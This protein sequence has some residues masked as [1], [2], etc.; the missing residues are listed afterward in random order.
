MEDLAKL[1]R[2][3]I[4][5]MPAA[6]RRWVLP[7]PPALGR[8][9]LAAL[10]WSAGPDL[11]SL[12][13]IEP[14]RPLSELSVR[15]WTQQSGI[16]EESITSL[17]FTPDGYV[18]GTSLN[19]LIRFDGKN[20][21]VLFPSRGT[22]CNDDTLA[23][24]TLADNGELWAA[25]SRGCLY[26]I[27]PD[28][29]GTFANPEITAES[30]PAKGSGR[31]NVSVALLNAGRG[32]LV[33][34]KTDEVEFWAP[35]RDQRIRRRTS[36]IPPAPR[37]I[38]AGTI[39]PD[40]ALWILEAD[41]SLYR[42][43]RGQWQ[44]QPI[45]GVITQSGQIRAMLVSR[46]G[47]VWVATQSGLGRWRRGQNRKF[48][49][50]SGLPPDDVPSLLEDRQGCIWAGNERGITRICGETVEQRSIWP[51]R[52]D[53]ANRIAEDRDGSIW[54]G[55]R[56]GRL[57][58]FSVPRFSVITN[59]EG[60]PEMR[61]TG[62]TEDGQGDLWVS[63]R[64]HGVCRVE[65]SRVVES[66]R[67]NG[68]PLSV[69]AI[70][71]L[72]D[73]GVLAASS[74]GFLTVNRRGV[75]STPVMGGV[76][77][78]SLGGLFLFG[79]DEYL[80]SDLRG[81][82]RL[83]MRHG[84]LHATPMEGPGQV[85]QWSLDGDGQIWALSYL[86]GLF[87]IEGQAYRKV[88]QLPP[89]HPERWLSLTWDEGILWIGTT[90]GLLAYSTGTQRYLGAEAGL[91]TDQI[92][93]I[94]RDRYDNLWIST[95]A[96]LVRVNRT[97]FLRWFEGAR[98]MPLVERFREQ[99]GLPTS[100]FGLVTSAS[101]WT[102]KSGMIWFPGIK[103]LVGVNPALFQQSA[104]APTPLLL[105]IRADQEPVDLKNEIV[106]R[107]RT[108]RV[109]F[110]FGVN[111]TVRGTGQLCR[112]QLVGFDPGW[113]VCRGELRAQYTNLK[114]GP[115]EFQLQTSSALEKW[116][117]ST[118]RVPLQIQAAFYETPAF[119]LGGI[120]SLLGLGLIVARIQHRR[121]VRQNV[122]L[123]ERVRHRTRELE[124]AKNAAESAMQAKSRFLATMSHEIR[125]PMNGVLGVA[126]VLQDS[127]LNEDQ[128]RMLDVIR[129][130]GEGLLAILDDIL[131]LAKMDAGKMRL[132]LKPFRVRTLVSEVAELFEA[133]GAQ[134]GVA[135]RTRVESDV[136]E[137]V[138][139]D[140]ARIRQILLNLTGNAVKF[141]EQGSV[142]IFV[143]LAGEDRSKIRFAVE[144]TGIGVSPEDL[145]RL[146]QDFEQV[147]SSPARRH[148]G[149]GLGLAIVR[150][151]AEAMDA[152]LLAESEPG[153]GSRFGL[154]LPL[155]PGAV[156][157]LEVP[158][159]AALSGVAFH[160]RVL[161]AEDNAVN[162][163]VVKRLLEQA[164]C[165][166]TVV[167]DGYEALEAL[168]SF[169]FDLV[170][171]DCQMPGIDGFEVTRRLRAKGGSFASLPVVA[172]TANAAAEDREQCRLAGMNGF[173]SKPLML[174]QLVQ[175]LA[176]YSPCTT[177]DTAG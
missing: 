78:S 84:V 144:D 28:R 58:R 8:L 171:L 33:L 66:F 156:E 99:H 45:E 93:H 90:S 117:G 70:A 67:P 175:T 61:V 129:N 106:L 110:E 148:T 26:R 147:D 94:A 130:S 169:P 141:T 87:R 125:T 57:V 69:S 23:A 43:E 25:S 60:L 139:G 89:V 115:Y 134:K 97:Q 4:G 135:V 151:L 34:V 51:D 86:A 65:Q 54:V 173:L 132:H 3:R 109:E 29:F 46:S 20:A 77:G 83:Q 177:T 124:Q 114:P 176:Q 22:R 174:E 71:P 111:A 133:R 42:H 82:F 85:R 31:L 55:G 103:G 152:S 38:R 75:A 91:S 126:Q 40:G 36:A 146:F 59:S 163:M 112:Y 95:R 48:Q 14:Q 41:G 73:G 63:S 5:S 168:E 138:W 162:R 17:A 88:T 81:C 142:T 13:A 116:D 92:F 105:R 165:D 167:Q 104:Q 15:T 113:L 11:L 155:R 79:R 49:I 52:E 72:P 6:I 170:L 2:K 12:R 9:L 153:K 44:P 161:A 62:I 149:T 56:W 74:G 18:W 76:S 136:P 50:V 16:P 158:R 53:Q 68:Q 159:G 101:G 21:R 128:R 47:D 150:R 1:R 119:Q 154:D 160:L 7:A 37:Q 166:A 140:P 145:A 100:N 80:Y 143:E 137:G 27:R 10:A 96:G 35:D 108:S 131:D 118:L 24:L 98:G 102:S 39:A 32:N 122:E 30:L 157:Q 120:L 19:G 164:G 127:P 172:L 121:L 64:E 107:A 123:E